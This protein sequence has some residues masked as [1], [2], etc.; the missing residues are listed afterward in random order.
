MK[1]SNIN[2]DVGHWSESLERLTCFY[3]LTL[4]PHFSDW[5]LGGQRALFRRRVNKYLGQA[6]KKGCTSSL[7]PYR[8]SGKEF[9]LVKCRHLS[10]CSLIGHPY[11]IGCGK[12]QVNK[13]PGGYRTPLLWGVTC[14]SKPWPL[15]SQSLSSSFSACDFRDYGA[16]K[17][18]I[19]EGKEEEPKPGEQWGY[20]RKAPRDPGPKYAPREQPPPHQEIREKH[21]GCPETP[22]I[23]GQPRDMAVA[24]NTLSW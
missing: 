5:W 12:K 15:A 7:F 6:R 13:P 22:R 19:M 10:T 8:H 1:S 21:W 16:R 18:K 20:R 14:H 17:S 11:S 23:W 9:R 4:L 3:D 2:G 24:S